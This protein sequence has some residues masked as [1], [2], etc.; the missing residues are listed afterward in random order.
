MS[1]LPDR[2]RLAVDR[3]KRLTPKR[4]LGRDERYLLNLARLQLAEWICQIQGLTP[5]YDTLATIL[6][7][8]IY[9]VFRAVP[10]ARYR[11]RA[12]SQ[13]RSLRRAA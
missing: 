3:I 9:H 4:I 10:E 12:Q 2:I 7:P 5:D 8:D 6:G 1:A 13:P 11:V